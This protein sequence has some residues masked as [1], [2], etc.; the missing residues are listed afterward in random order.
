MKR[1]LSKITV[2]AVML[3][4][5]LCTSA[6]MKSSYNITV[7]EKGMASSSIKLL[8]P[9][10]EAAREKIADAYPSCQI[11]PI[12]ERDLQGYLFTFEPVRAEDLSL[13]GFISPKVS[14]EHNYF[15][16][17]Y[18]LSCLSMRQASEDRAYRRDLEELI[19]CL[20]LDGSVYWSL[21]LPCEPLSHNAG[22]CGNEG[23]TLIGTSSD[24]MKHYAALEAGERGE[25]T[26]QNKMLAADDCIRAEFRI[27]KITSF[28]NLITLLIVFCTVMTVWRC[29]PGCRCRK[30]EEEDTVFYGP[31]DDRG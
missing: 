26:E 30:K 17:T 21:T 18:K 6:C 1:L 25:A 29:Y 31:G 23:K 14:K 15:Y 16:D 22:R 13:P 10:A 20:N 9:Y 2:L 3:G 4:M 19:S 8:G 24:I 12:R 28:I 27:Y 5:L 11:E 7:D